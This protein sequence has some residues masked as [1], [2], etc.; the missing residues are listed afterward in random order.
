ML[1]SQQRVGAREYCGV[2]ISL[3]HGQ[4]EGST[5]QRIIILCNDVLVCASRGFTAEQRRR[6]GI[7][8]CNKTETSDF[9]CC[10]LTERDLEKLN[11]E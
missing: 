7:S 4:G 2:L 10:I 1:L 6:P 3:L 9:S 8:F 5:E 11:S